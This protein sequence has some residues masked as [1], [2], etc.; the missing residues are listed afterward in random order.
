MKKIFHTK[1]YIAV[2]S[3]IVIFLIGTLY[4]RFSSNYSWVD[5]FYFTVITATTVGFKEVHPLTEAEKIFTTGL[6]LASIF[7]LGFAI[8]VITEN[9]FSKNVAHVLN[10]ETQRKYI[11]GLK[12]LITKAQEYYP[13]DPSRSVDFVKKE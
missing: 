1:L 9:I 13:T 7:V 6:I 2:I 5:A 12:R 8:T 10:D 11:Q 4:F 3:L